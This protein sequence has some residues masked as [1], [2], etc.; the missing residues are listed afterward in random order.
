MILDLIL[1][2]L[3]A[4]WDF[5]LG[6]IFALVVTGAAILAWTLVRAVI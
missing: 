5:A 6:V 3:S 2:F 4:L 1:N